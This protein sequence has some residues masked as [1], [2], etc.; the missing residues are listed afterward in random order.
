[1]IL[2]DLRD[3]VLVEGSTAKLKC[4]VSA[5]PDPFIV[6][7]KYCYVFED[8][9]VLALVNFAPHVR[10]K[11]PA[12]NSKDPDNIK[13]KRGTTVVLKAEISRQPPPVVVWL[14]VVASRFLH[15]HIVYGAQTGNLPI[16]RQTANS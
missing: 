10:Y 8:P 12:K 5:F 9:D 2:Q 14:K 4:S 1:K 15:L 6:G 13:T 7:P 11:V 3:V 16:T